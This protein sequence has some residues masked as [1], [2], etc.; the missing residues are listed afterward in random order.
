MHAASRHETV[1][2]AKGRSR[3]LRV[4]A[5][6]VFVIMMGR[7]GWLQLARG[8]FYRDLSEENYVQGFEV[9]APRGL[10]TD[11]N[12]EILADNRASLSITV[13]RMRGRDDRALAA[14]LSELL[15]LDPASVA[16]KLNE[17][18]TKYYGSIVLVEDAALDV[19]SRIEERRSELPGVKV[20]T[21]ATR[22]YPGGMLAAHAAGYVAE[23]TEEELSTMSALGY[24]PG[25]YVGRSG[26][27]RR[28]ESLL[29]GRDGA[30]YWVCD[31]SGRE[32]YPFAG[33]PSLEAKPGHNLV[34]TLDAPAQAAAELALSAYGAGAVV[35]IEPKTGEILVLASRPAPDPN[36]I[37]DGLSP[38]EWISLVESPLHPM[39]NRAI[40]SAYPPGSQFKIVT[41]GT[42]LSTGAITRDT[43]VV[44]DGSFRYGVRTFHCWRKEGHGVMDLLAGITESCDV[45]FYTVGARLG[46]ATLMAWTERCHFGVPTGVDIPG[47]AR[48]NVPTPAWYDR[49]YGKRKWSKGLVVNLAIGQGELLVTPLQAAA[50]TCGIANGG[51]VV[52]PHLFKRAE[53]YSGRVIA[54]ARPTVAWTL[55]FD[56]A[57]ISFLRA[58]MVNVVQAPNG[59]GKQARI[60]GMEVGGKTGTAQNP[61]GES[62]AW[63]ASFAPADDPK[64][65]VAVLVENSGGGGAIAAPIARKVMK[66]YFRIPE[67]PPVTPPAAPL[68]AQEE[69]TP[70]GQETPEGL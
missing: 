47:E 8:E 37:V 59:T 38:D 5:A 69:G 45:Y 57:T 6:V 32:L 23:I 15:G 51:A 65:V 28:Y 17:V 18:K 35:A 53:T 22:R 4:A 48:G 24:A 7:L 68:A 19:V 58:A 44:C 42:A 41:A 70:D 31:A 62:H 9:R 20:Q 29:R 40:Q 1:E 25:H 55:P 2:T 63:F 10:I 27:E 56:Q 43:R 49:H 66:A 52:R 30:E 16:R 26:V 50:F 34:L 21:T 54:T 64:I 11:R 67:E 12:G 36:A 60:P 14:K 46:V 61:H 3:A 13:S 39:L 33:G